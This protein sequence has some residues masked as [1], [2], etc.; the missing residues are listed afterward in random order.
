MTNEASVGESNAFIILHNVVE[1]NNLNN[2]HQLI[3]Y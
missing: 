1:F 3:I 2:F